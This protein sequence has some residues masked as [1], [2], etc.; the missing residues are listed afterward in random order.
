MSAS[1][2]VT[3]NASKPDKA[4]ASI[5]WHLA[6]ASAPY[7]GLISALWATSPLV[8]RA[9]LTRAASS[10]R[11]GW[12]RHPTRLLARLN[13]CTTCDSRPSGAPQVVKHRRLLAGQVAKRQR[14]SSDFSLF[15]TPL[16][17]DF[18]RL[19]SF[20]TLLPTHERIFTKPVLRL[21]GHFQT[22]FRVLPHSPFL[23]P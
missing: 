12:L 14:P 3:G 22:H 10:R 7:V 23:P 8:F 4:L 20:Q 5:R 18:P 1:V 16:H 13:T 15:K 2:I 11:V 9:R 6:H 17:V 21:L 19:L